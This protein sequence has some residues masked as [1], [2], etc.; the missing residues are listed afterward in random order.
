[1]ESGRLNEAGSAP[2]RR[3][4]GIRVADRPRRGDIE[5]RRQAT[6]PIMRDG[7]GWARGEPRVRCPSPNLP[8]AV[9]P[10]HQT[11]RGFMT[12]AA[13]FSRLP[14]IRLRVFRSRRA[15]TSERTAP[16]LFA[17]CL[18]V[19]IAQLDSTVVYLAVKHIG[20]D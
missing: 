4:S 11:E 13:V 7:H 1:M 12:R 8:I 18:G 10:A 20:G 2:S 5:L 15:G 17:M 16:I 3:P 19:F 9:A 6:G 14:P